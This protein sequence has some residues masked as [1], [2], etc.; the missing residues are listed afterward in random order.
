MTKNTRIQNNFEQLINNI[1]AEIKKEPWYWHLLNLAWTA[2]PVT[3]ITVYIAYYIGYRKLIHF[4]TIIYFGAYTVF[5]GLFAI[6]FQTVKNAAIT[7]Q[8]RE[9]K[10]QLHLVID[11]FLDYTYFCKEN[12]AFSLPTN[13]QDMMYSWWVLTSSTSDINMIQQAVFLATKN[14]EL[15]ESIK[16]IEFFRKLGLD[17]Q[18]LIE[19]DRVKDQFQKATQKIAPIFPSLAEVLEMRFKGKIRSTKTGVERPQ[20]FLS[21][22]L[23]AADKDSR[24]YVGI[25][26]LIAVL[27]LS[28]ELIMDRKIL[29]FYP[30]FNDKN[31]EVF[32]NEYEEKISDFKLSKRL[33]NNNVKE[34]ISIVNENLESKTFAYFGSN[35]GQLNDI[36]SEIKKSSKC[37][38]ILTKKEVKKLIEQIK[39]KNKKMKQI[40]A[41][42]IYIYYKKIKVANFDDLTFSLKENFI[43]IDDKHKIKIVNTLNEIIL[44]KDKKNCTIEDIKDICFDIINTLDEQMN[45][46]EPEEQIAIE[47]SMATDLNTIEPNF[48]TCHKISSIANFVNDIQQTKTKTVNRFIKHLIK[49]Y[50]FKI[51]DELKLKVM[52]DFHGQQNC[53]DSVNELEDKNDIN[54]LEELK[55]EIFTEI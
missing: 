10:Y 55:Q 48:S 33:R 15:T 4:E 31:F 53:I 8:L 54:F 37:K 16:Q 43:H 49:F 51:S 14:K 24:E 28:I 23:N 13:Q 11:K 42:L 20:G 34:L 35:S 45:I 19:F 12:L 41:R 44:K 27:N 50:N 25:E 46:S 5:A 40:I 39:A 6:I 1:K 32:F 22:I 9:Y 29:V 7:P 21:R 3:I 52:S 38:K 26:D 47:E 36:L 30:E 17:K 2:G 18:L